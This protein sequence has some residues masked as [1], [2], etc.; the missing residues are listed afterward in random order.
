[1]G[2]QFGLPVVGDV[3]PY[4]V[5]KLFLGWWLLE[6]EEWV[7]KIVIVTDISNLSKPAL[8]AMAR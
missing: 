6:Q 8:V 1:M 2:T 4:L 3:V 5:S 7:G